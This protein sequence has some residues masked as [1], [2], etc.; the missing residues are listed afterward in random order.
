MAAAWTISCPGHRCPPRW[1]PLGSEL[2]L[3]RITLLDGAVFEPAQAQGKPLPVYRWSITCPFCAPQSL[4]METLWQSQK[5]RGLQM[6]ALSIDKK[7]E[8]AVAWPDLNGLRF[9]SRQPASFGPQPRL[10]RHDHPDSI[11]FCLAQA[12]A[13]RLS[14]RGRRDLARPVPVVDSLFGGHGGPA[15]GA[16]PEP[17]GQRPAVL[18]LRHTQGAVAADRGGVRH[19]HGQHLVHA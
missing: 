12:S 7:P 14:G 4:S 13:H 17:H 2:K 5:A 18:L 8:D 1:P 3:P 19:G 11:P 10:P 9:F 6:V 16:A 15:A